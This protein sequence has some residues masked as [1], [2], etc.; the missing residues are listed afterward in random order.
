MIG[1]ATV[2]EEQDGKIICERIVPFENTAKTLWLQFPDKAAYA[3][4]EKELLNIL[5]DSDGTDEVGI[6]VS[7]PRAMKKLG[8]NWN[9]RA[10][11]DLLAKLKEFLG[12]KNVVLKEKSIENPVK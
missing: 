10:D 3:A 6:Y 9:V 1:R 5:K 7:N 11:S 12:E 4:K 8:P 2:E